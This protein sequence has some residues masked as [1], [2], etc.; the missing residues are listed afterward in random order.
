M[1]NNLILS[2]VIPTKDRYSY[3]KIL[4]KSIT[5][6][7]SNQYEIIITDNSEI[8]IEILSFLK[9]IN[10]NK[11]KYYHNTDSLSMSENFNFGVE[12]ANGEYVIVL[13]DD[14]GIL[15]DES[16]EFLNECYHQGIEAIQTIPIVYQWPDNSHLVWGAFGGTFY[17]DRRPVF[18]NK[19]NVKK[20]LNKQINYGFGYGLGN[21]PRVYQGFVLNVCLKKLK[22]K[23]GTSFPGPSPDMA[24]AVGLCSI[25]TKAVFTNKYLVVSGHSKK[26]AGGMGGRKEHVAEISDVD[27]LPKETKDL[28]SK[29]IPFYWTGPTIYS[30]SARLALI[31]TNINLVEKINY[32]YLYA[33]LNIYEK[34]CRNRTKLTIKNNNHN[35]IFLKL[36]RYYIYIKIFIKRSINFL[37]NLLK[38]KVTNDTKAKDISEVI[39]IIKSK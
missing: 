39:D 22:E 3:L 16:V 10:S 33:I 29:K 12:K 13:G 26:S 38:Y 28:W 17:M 5:E 21:L 4:L 30:E 23:C 35:T 14:D 15:I 37:S 20:E 34:K 8:N 18:V 36:N 2:V 25:I 31:R 24:N 7:Q 11:I 32:N 9:D 6:S 1:K 19:I 27:W